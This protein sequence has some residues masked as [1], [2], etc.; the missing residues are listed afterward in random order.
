V[1]GVRKRGATSRLKAE[2][3]LVRRRAIY[4]V[5]LPAWAH[6]QSLEAGTESHGP[7]AHGPEGQKDSS[8]IKCLGQTAKV[9]DPEPRTAD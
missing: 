2:T 8:A 6:G 1:S 5:Q 9:D 3:P 4:V 7:R